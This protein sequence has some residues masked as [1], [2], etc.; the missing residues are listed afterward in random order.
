MRQAQVLS[1]H[2][3]PF[4]SLDWK[5]PRRKREWWHRRTYQISTQWILSP[6]FFLKVIHHYYNYYIQSRKTFRTSKRCIS[7]WNMVLYTQ[8]ILE[9]LKLN[10]AGSVPHD[11]QQ[12]SLQVLIAWLRPVERTMFVVGLGNGGTNITNH[13]IWQRFFL[14]NKK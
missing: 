13:G 10:L 6:E 8:Q 4:M 2:F 1:Q 14:Q 9:N 3:W 5:G 7:S 11:P 12:I